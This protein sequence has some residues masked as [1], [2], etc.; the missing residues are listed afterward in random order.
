MILFDIQTFIGY[1]CAERNL[2]MKKIAVVL[3]STTLPSEKLKNH[4]DVY[5]APLEVIANGK[6]YVDGVDIHYQDW[7]KFL[8]EDATMST[9]QPSLLN[10]LNVLN[11]VKNA[12]YDHVFVLTLS[13]HLSGTHNG[14]ELANKEV[15]IENIDIIDTLSIAGPITI[16]AEK[17]LEY[18]E[19]SKSIEE[20]RQMIYTL[21]DHNETYIYPATLKRLIFSGRMNKTVGSLANLLKLKVLLAL[22]N[23]AEQIDKHD[24]VRTEKKLISEVVSQL[25]KLG[26]NST[27][28]VI[29]MLELESKEKS[30]LFED[31]IVNRFNGIEVRREMLPGVIATHVGLGVVG[32]QAVRKEIS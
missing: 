32:I 26:V 19:N 24:V 16:M 14:F 29:Y 4:P 10:T 31:A 9:S 17:I 22:K 25:E 7:V 20:I 11:K 21:M 28:W 6:T 2:Y 30:Q 27:D 23:K 13:G 1:N 8:E 18:N 5:I 15:G 3:D 12:N